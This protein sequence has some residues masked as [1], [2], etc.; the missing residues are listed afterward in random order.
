[1]RDERLA[2]VIRQRIEE[3]A[4]HNGKFY[5]GLTFGLI[6]GF[7][8]ST[9]SWTVSANSPSPTRAAV[10]ECSS[11]YSMVSVSDRD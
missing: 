8:S 11:G 1:M 6:L 9:L 3:S 5:A 2:S 10:V 7:A 4:E